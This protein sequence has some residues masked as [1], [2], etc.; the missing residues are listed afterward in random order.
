MVYGV[1]AASLQFG[2]V[3]SHRCHLQ[4][5]D[6]LSKTKGIGLQFMITTEEF[7]AAAHKAGVANRRRICILGLHCASSFSLALLH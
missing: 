5:E 6:D 7:E 3:S 1:G 2:S 4:Q